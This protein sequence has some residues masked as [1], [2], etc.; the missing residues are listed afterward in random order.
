[1]HV[2]VCTCACVCVLICL[3]V[4]VL[5]LCSCCGCCKQHQSR[6]WRCR[7][8]CEFT[9]CSSFPHHPCHGTNFLYVQGGAEA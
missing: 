1:M 2:R 6:D 7:L 5:G 8:L 3:Y 9:G 4:Y